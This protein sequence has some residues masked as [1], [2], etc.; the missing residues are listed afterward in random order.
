MSE[1]TEVP[2]P[3]EQR[4]RASNVDFKLREADAYFGKR[5]PLHAV[6]RDLDRRLHEADIPYALLG[7]MAMHLHG[8]ERMTTD[9]DL[10]MTR[11]AIDKFKA[12]C[13]GRGYV[14]AFPG[15]RKAF[16]E[17]EHGVR[18]DIIAAGEFPG[19]GKAKPVSFPNPAQASVLIDGISVISL[20]KLIELKLASGM[21]ATHRLKDLGDVTDLI[22]TLNLPADLADGL[23]PSVRD[24]YLELWNAMQEDDPVHEREPRT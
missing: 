12:H 6:L 24:K 20:P 22:R 10:L 21:T 5:G 4:L 13:V 17:T 18:I 3:Y 1:V 9:L 16:R 11:E 8:H 15:A 14:P 23:D 7:A 2:I 19:D